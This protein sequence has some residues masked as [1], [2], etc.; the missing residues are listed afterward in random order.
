MHGIDEALLLIINGMRASWCDRVAAW[1]T[2][3]G[4]Y[5]LLASMPLMALR[6]RTRQEVARARDGV[7][8]FFLAMFA[9]ETL[10][11][12]LFE[13]ARPSAIAA[14]TSQLHILG[15]RPSAHSFSFP[16]GTVTVCV[17]AA[18]WIWLHWGR[19]AGIIATLF[20]TAVAWSRLYAGVHW[21]TDVVAGAMLGT[22]VAY[23]VR[24]LTRWTEQVS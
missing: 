13:R 11:K 19:R 7:F 20:A 1:L 10:I 9:A 6:T 22:T 18:V 3:W 16:S 5:V 2:E 21:P 14:L 17:T 8:A 12:P 24:A 4:M 23:A 15:T